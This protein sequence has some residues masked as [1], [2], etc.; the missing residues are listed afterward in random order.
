MQRDPAK[1]K[2]WQERGARRYQERL[3][4]R[5]RNGIEKAPERQRPE[6]PKHAPKARRN[7]GPWRE[8][9]LTLR[10][11]Y[12]RACGRANVKLEADHMKP[13]SQGGLS[14]VE[15]GLILCSEHHEQKTLSKLQIR[16]EWLDSDQVAWLAREGWVVWDESGDVSGRGMRHFLPDSGRNT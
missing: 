13:R 5:A 1:A 11:R 6:K 10:G 4:A 7:Y 3:E 2:A 15:N 16:K 14:V 9:C 12:C 8:A